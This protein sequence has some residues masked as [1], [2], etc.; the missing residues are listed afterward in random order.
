MFG[1]KV[2]A[3][4]IIIGAFFFLGSKETASTVFQVKTEGFLTEIGMYISSKVPLSKIS[5]I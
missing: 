3:P 1:M 4:I 5:V 2:F